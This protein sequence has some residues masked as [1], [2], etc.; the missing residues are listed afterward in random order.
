MTEFSDVYYLGCL[1]YTSANKFASQKQ[2]MTAK[3]SR[4]ENEIVEIEEQL[5][6]LGV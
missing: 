6:S 5:K 3:L 1:L 4:T 2:D